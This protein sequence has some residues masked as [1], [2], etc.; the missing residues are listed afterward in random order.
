MWKL[1]DFLWCVGEDK[2]GHEEARRLNES[3]GTLYVPFGPY[4]PA[5]AGDYTQ[6]CVLGD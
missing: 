2:L 1:G 5:C 4:N 6:A 3:C